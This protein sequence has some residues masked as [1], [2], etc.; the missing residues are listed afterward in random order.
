MTGFKSLIVA[1]ALS[2]VAL[3]G[4]AGRGFVAHAADSP[5][6]TSADK[7]PA[8]LP[9][10]PDPCLRVE[11]Q[12][13]PLR[14][15]NFDQSAAW[16]RI[17]GVKG[18]DLPRTVLP[19]VDG[20]QI[21]IG[22]STPYD[23]RTGLSAPQVEIL[24]T[25]KVGK[26]IVEK[27][28]P[29]KDL[30]HVADAVLLKDRIVVMTQIGGSTEAGG[31]IGL[32]FLNGA[33][34]EKSSQIISDK[35]V[36]YVPKSLVALVGNEAIV[37]AAEARPRKHPAD[38]YTVL[39]WVD[40]TGR[41]VSQKDYLPG[42]INKPEYIGRLGSSELVVTGR[43]SGEDGRDAGWILR[44]DAKGTIIYQRPYARGGD[45]LIRH[46]I[47]LE[48]GDLLAI[49]DAIPA[50]AGDKAAWVM[51]VNPEGAPVWQTYLTGKYS[52]AGVDIINMNDGR[53]NAL[54]AGRPTE[55]GGRRYARIV[56]LST[57][58][59]VIGDESFIEGSN[60]IP[61]RLINQKGRRILLGMVET[62]FSKKDAPD[63]LKY[64]A[65]DSWLLELGA[66]PNFNTTCAGSPVRTL[67]DLP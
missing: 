39:V 61:V 4:F 8:K 60:A 25:D 56:T 18:A 66:L 57:D 62:G 32:R 34:E 42:V 2:G 17:S 23:E 31:A 43:V 26:V 12:I 9:K 28:V 13:V 19:V 15:P 50:G 45:S 10:A 22:T 65:Y 54:L 14:V 59:V 21:V 46:A 5:A 41:V 6:T 63:D 47:P 24:R 37:I 67:D 53:V 29:V 16:K 27:W 36:T 55:S 3:A 44:L 51:R 30:H 7:K 38:V 40:K 48:N 52:Y 35:V 49:G 33:G 20:G 11:E 1:T 58:G 64:V